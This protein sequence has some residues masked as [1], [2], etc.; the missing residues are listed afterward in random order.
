MGI[1]RIVTTLDG[2][3]VSDFI[4]YWVTS[5]DAQRKSPPQIAGLCR[6]Y[7]SVENLNHWKRDAVW[8]EDRSRGRNP[9]IA[10]NL[11][12]IRATLL[13]PLTRADFAS[14]PEA[15][16]TLA[17]NQNQAIALIRNQ[18]LTWRQPKALIYNRA[19]PIWAALAAKDGKYVADH[20][21][22]LE[23][24][25]TVQII[26]GHPEPAIATLNT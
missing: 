8:H 24:I 11:A 17:Q 20:C 1:R 12:L 23:D 6:E 21:E 26:E 9:N 25:S 15:L 14:L 16:E 7:W 18:R 3:P 10:R 22:T 19:L 2:T 13:A 4:R 5:I